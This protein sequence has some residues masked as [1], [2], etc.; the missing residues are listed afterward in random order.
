MVKEL[1]DIDSVNLLSASAHVRRSH[2][3]LERVLPPSMKVGVISAPPL[4]YNAE[5][6]WLSKKGIW[7][8]FKNTFSILYSLLFENCKLLECES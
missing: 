3:I 2:L 5:F 7:V 1:L 4:S 8:V 6:W